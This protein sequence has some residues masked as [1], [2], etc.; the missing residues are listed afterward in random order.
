MSISCLLIACSSNNEEVAGKNS[1]NHTVVTSEIPVIDADKQPSTENSSEMSVMNELTTDNTFSET[2][3]SIADRNSEEIVKTDKNSANIAANTDKLQV[4]GVIDGKLIGNDSGYKFYLDKNCNI[5]T[6]DSA[7]NRTEHPILSDYFGCLVFALNNI[8]YGVNND[9]ADFRQIDQVASRDRFLGT[10]DKN[11][12]YLDESNS[13]YSIT[14]DGRNT[15]IEIISYGEYFYFACD[16]AINKVKSDGTEFKQLLS[17]FSPA[18]GP[19]YEHF[20]KLIKIEDGIIYYTD[21]STGDNLDRQI[22]ITGDILFGGEPGIP[23]V[24]TD[25]FVGDTTSYSVK[26]VDSNWSGQGQFVTYGDNGIMSDMTTPISQSNLFNR[27]LNNKYYKGSKNYMVEVE[28]MVLDKIG[29][30]SLNEGSNNPGGNVGFFIGL[31]YSNQ[32]LEYYNT[33]TCKYGDDNTANEGIER[34]NTWYKMKMVRKNDTVELYLNDNLLQTIALRDSD[35]DTDSI[36]ICTS[37][38]GNCFRNFQFTRED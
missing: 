36:G 16:S 34:F 12:F 33:I 11:V 35:E 9:G 1:A 6:I 15:A 3:P 27:T 28:V 2:V 25:P 19:H 23:K 26:Q 29:I 13:I 24:F 7:G 8:I 4:S 37:S 32:V 10:D 30:P 5:F 18:V 22:T 21:T 20:L 31:D 17:E 38:P 14:C